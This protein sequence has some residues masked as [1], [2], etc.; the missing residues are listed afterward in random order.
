MIGLVGVFNPLVRELNETLY[1]FEEPF[2]PDASRFQA[3]FGAFE[4]TPTD[5]VRHTVDW[6]RQ[7]YAARSR[8]TRSG[9]SCREPST[10]DPQRWETAREL[11]GHDLEELHLVR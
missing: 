7:R 11:I 8:W 3:A 2:V 10:R 4:P 6:F 5:A 9:C 1:P